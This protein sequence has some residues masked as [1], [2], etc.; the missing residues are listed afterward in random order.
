MKR[1]EV[2][3]E[4]TLVS[5]FQKIQAAN[6]SDTVD[7]PLPKGSHGGRTVRTIWTGPFQFPEIVRPPRPFFLALFFKVRTKKNSSC[8]F[9]RIGFVRAT[10]VRRA[11]CMKVPSVLF[12]SSLV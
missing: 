7:A 12:C 8:L 2:G 3:N 9:V 1:Q 4:S 10:S 6:V 5:M 11:T